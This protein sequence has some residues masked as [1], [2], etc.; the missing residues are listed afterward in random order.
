[1]ES[2]PVL[3]NSKRHSIVWRA[4]PSLLERDFPCPF[5]SI[6]EV[7]ATTRASH[8]PISSRHSKL[9]LCPWAMPSMALS[10]ARQRRRKP[11]S[12]PPP[13]T[14][15]ATSRIVVF[16][17]LEL[18]MK[19]NPPPSMPI[20]RKSGAANAVQMAR[21]NCELSAQILPMLFCHA[22]SVPF[23]L[24]RFSEPMDSKYM[25]VSGEILYTTSGRTKHP[26][27]Q[28]MLDTLRITLSGFAVARYKY[29]CFCAPGAM[30]K[31]KASSIS[32]KAV[33]LPPSICAGISHLCHLPSG[34]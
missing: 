19:W 13:Q 14:L 20:N 11:S 10:V 17:R 2:S 22:V 3:R 23:T 32:R 28:P 18:P 1:M 34:V 31:P 8:W 6:Y 30:R 25:S 16:P 33:P 26:S 24:K 9:S 27:C 15:P 7:S 29:K 4:V 12:P 5:A 21:V